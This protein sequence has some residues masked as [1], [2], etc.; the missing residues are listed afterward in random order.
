MSRVV[1]STT[2]DG[3]ERRTYDAAGRLLTFVDAMDRAF[4]ISRREDG[5]ITGVRDPA[6][7]R[8]T[9]VPGRRGEV[10]ERTDPRGA[11]TAYA[12]DARGQ[13]TAVEGPDGSKETYGYDAHGNLIEHTTPR[14]GTFRYTF[15]LLGQLVRSE[16]PRGG[17]YSLEYDSRGQLTRVKGRHRPTGPATASGTTRGGAWPGSRIPP[18]SASPSSATWR[19]T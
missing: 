13:V 11:K 2:A 10:K 5:A 18:A 7:E 1:R 8:Y 12:Y 14:G 19:A 4:S 17:V 15:D 3:T 9:L 6:G 16:T